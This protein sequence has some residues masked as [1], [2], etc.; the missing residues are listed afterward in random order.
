[1]FGFDWEVPPGWSQDDVTAAAFLAPSHEDQRPVPAPW[2]PDTRPT[3]EANATVVE[4]ALND[5]I[6]D[7]D[8]CTITVAT[9]GNASASTNMTVMYYA[10]GDQ[11]LGPVAM[12]LSMAVAEG[13]TEGDL[14]AS[15]FV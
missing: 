11:Q 1:M 4:S 12:V 15:H 9:P 14:L 8:L 6:S 2:H 3:V 7:L 5:N 13:V 10:W